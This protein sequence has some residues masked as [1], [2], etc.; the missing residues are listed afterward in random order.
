MDDGVSLVRRLRTVSPAVVDSVLAAV[1]FAVAMVETITELD[2][3]CVT[4]TDV[5]LTVGFLLAMTVPLVGRRRHPFVVLTV[6]GLAKVLYSD[7]LDMQPDPVTAVFPVLLAVYSV[8]AYARRSLAVA[9]GILTLIALV[10]FN[11]SELGSD[12]ADLATQF[13]F[14]G[15]AWIVGDNTRY[16]RRQAELLRERAERAEREREEQAR[17]GAMEERARIAREIHDVVTHSVSVIAVQAGA[18]RTV[19]DTQP[20]KAREALRSIERVRPGFGAGPGTAGRRRGRRLGPPG[21]AGGGG[22]ADPARRSWPGG[23]GRVRVPGGGGP[24]RTAPR[25]RRVGRGPGQ[26]GR[27]AARDRAWRGGR[28]RRPGRHG[29]GRHRPARPGAGRAHR[30]PP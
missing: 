11:I 29:D 24:R 4:R 10:V 23:P 27:P 6:V 13:A 25:R 26:G 7:I 22:R 17:L 12:F 2:C 30:A 14:L 9:G 19:V 3:H 18:A 1:L 16:R 28:E 5:T 15:G 8:A 20:E 21:D